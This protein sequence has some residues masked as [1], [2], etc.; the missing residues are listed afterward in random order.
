M[1]RCRR[2]RSKEINLSKPPYQHY[3]GQ[4]GQF[5][6]Q[7]HADQPSRSG[8]GQQLPGRSQPT[9]SGRAQHRHM[10]PPS[11]PTRRRWPWAV[12]GIVLLLV[13][14]VAAGG[15]TTAP[16]T[17]PS[18]AG[19]LAQAP[20][21]PDTA[22]EPSVDVIT[23]EVIG[24]SVDEADN[25][26]YIKDENFG[27]QQENGASL[28]WKKEIEFESGLFVQPLSLVAVSGSGGS[29]SITCRILR[30]GEEVTSSTSS[31]PYALVSCSGGK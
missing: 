21:A 3:Q 14:G 9:G 20:A 11:E 17:A 15:Q 1:A 4:P 12:G 5:S 30:N 8:C 7:H 28:P 18:T 29:G 10:P 26:T 19:E 23:Y 13:I 31:G 16:T 6:P 22:G 2:G 27:Q 24:D 25:I